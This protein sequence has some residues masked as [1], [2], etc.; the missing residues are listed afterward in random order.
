ME[1][2]KRL[3]HMGIQQR[4]MLYVTVGLALMFGGFAFVGLRS[5]QEATQLVYK[6]RLSETHT[7][8]GLFSNDFS[9]V[10]RGAKAAL[11]KV[12]PEDRQGIE[13]ATS[14]LLDSLSSDSFNFFRVTGVW[15]IDAKG[16]LLADAGTP[17][18]DTSTRLLPAVSEASAVTGED[19]VLLPA[20]GGSDGNPPFA[21]LATKVG[22]QEGSRT[23]VIVVHT[24]SLNNQTSYNPASF[25]RTGQDA[26]NAHDATEDSHQEY[27]LE[28]VNPEGIT[29]LLIWK[30]RTAGK[31]SSHY[32]FVRSLAYGESSVISHSPGPSDSFPPHVIAIV[33]IGSSRFYLILEQPVDVALA[34]P[35]RIKQEILVLAIGG[36]LITLFVAW[37]TTRNVVKPTRQ[38]TRAAERMARGDLETPISINSQDE[39]G[40]LA[41]SLDIMRLELKE[42]SEQIG[43]VNKEL[44]S[45]VRERTARL[46]DVLQ[47]VIT[48]QEDE[49]YRLARELHDETLQTL[50]ALSIALDRARDGLHDTP[51]RSAEHLVEAKAIAGRLLEE[52][53]RLIL[54]LRPMALDD[55]GLGPAI[56]W[57]AETHLEGKGVA[58][59]VEVG[60]PVVKLPKHIEVTL[61]RLA[62][63]AV[64]NIAKH[65]DARHAS[66][67][68]T[69]PD[70]LAS[71][72]VTDDGKGFDVN[73][74]LQLGTSVPN[75]GLLGMQERVKLLNG[76]FNIRSQQGKGTEV[77]VEIPVESESA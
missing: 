42:A 45:Q 3:R 25:W 34:L 4:I 16:Q 17:K 50:G 5:V 33:P 49:R 21:M 65:A 2:L 10:A 75:V 70:S 40:K 47:K 73:H 56:R 29:A 62:Q 52:T 31:P 68:V 44:E 12:T 64:N 8:A 32:A 7:T 66:I 35:L 22:G 28:V 61:F 55:L 19:Y 1:T 46:A 30:G 23:H 53:R 74:A 51:R 41:Q 38:L 24:A 20:V 72:V 71:L 76:R 13:A 77:N 59:S 9:R 57:Y 69:F 6:E 26:R 43:N 54:G 11:S 15:V 27:H 39:V 58:T 14:N 37:I 60:Q 36:F 18:L 48:A 63:E 67:R